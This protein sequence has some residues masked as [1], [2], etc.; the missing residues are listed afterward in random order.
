MKGVDGQTEHN[1]DFRKRIEIPFSQPFLSREYSSTVLSPKEVKKRGN[2]K[3]LT[4]INFK[5]GL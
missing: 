5:I 4:D 3:K 1:E 2:F